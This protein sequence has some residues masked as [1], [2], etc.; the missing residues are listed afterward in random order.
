MIIK[1]SEFIKSVADKKNLI[2]DGK[3]QIAFVGRSNVGKSSLI[4][5]L[6]NNKK[7]AK[8]SSTPGLTKLI[9]YFLINKEFYFVDLPGYGYAKGAKD[10]DFN[11]LIEPYFVNNNLLRCVCI[12]VD[13]RLTPNELDKQMLEFL[14]YYNTPYLIIATKSDKIS[15]SQIYLSK[16]KI[17]KELNINIDNVIITSNK[18]G[19]GKTELLQKFD[20]M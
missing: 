9:N 10:S 1:N 8:T 16:T 11:K 7:L 12:L 13:I 17:A 19:F 15:N 3:N 5:M 20:N 4:N 6:T 14:D 2:S 18:T